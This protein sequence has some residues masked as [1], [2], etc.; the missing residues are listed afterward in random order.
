M[1]SNFR[2]ASGRAML[3]A[4]VVG[5]GDP[6]VFLHAR[7]ADSR[8]WH[9]QLDG[10]GAHNKAIAYDRRGFGETRADE[11]DFSAVADLMAVIDAMAHGKP[12]ILVGCSQGGGIVLDAALRHPSRVRALVLIAPNVTGAPEAIGSPEIEGLRMQLK[13]AEK[14]RR[15][16]SGDRDQNTP[17]S[18]RPTRAR[19]SCY[20]SGSPTVPRHELSCAQVCADRGES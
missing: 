3:A 9:D 20:G 6:V 8:M 15:Y 10:V 19:R 1:S 7:V 2:I 16:R 4:K 12:V 11:E 13:Q 5:N 17:F 14:G 18:G